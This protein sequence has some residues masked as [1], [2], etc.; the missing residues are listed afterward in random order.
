MSRVSSKKRRE[1]RN[2]VLIIDDDELFCDALQEHL[3]GEFMEVKTAYT[4]KAGVEICS[5]HRVDVVLLDE[6]P[7]LLR[8]SVLAGGRQ[9]TAIR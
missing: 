4:G 2:V 3:D 8:H 6:A 1:R 9:Q 7:E 5:K